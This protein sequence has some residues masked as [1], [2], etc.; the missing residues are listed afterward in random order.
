MDANDPK[1][2]ELSFKVLE[3]IIMKCEDNDY[4]EIMKIAQI[5]NKSAQFG[6]YPEEIKLA[7]TDAI[8]KLQTLNQ[9]QIND[10]REMLKAE[11]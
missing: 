9:D 5:M 3:S 10:L 1:V 11:E 8:S 7:Y 6:N 2:I 4:D